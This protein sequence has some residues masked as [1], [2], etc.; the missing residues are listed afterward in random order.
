MPVSTRHDATGRQGALRPQRGGVVLCAREEGRRDDAV[1][2]VAVHLAAALGAKL[3]CVHPP[4][5]RPSPAA[6]ADPARVDALERAARRFAADWIVIGAE[7]VPGKSSALAAQLV[8]DLR[9][10]VVVVRRAPTRDRDAWVLAQVPRD[11]VLSRALAVAALTCADALERPLMAACVL[12]ATPGCSDG[13][14]DLE[15]RI[16]DLLEERE[17][18]TRVAALLPAGKELAGVH[19]QLRRG[20]IATE[21]GTAARELPADVAVVAGD[22]ESLLVD[23]THERLFAAGLAVVVTV[24]VPSGRVGRGTGAR[25]MRAAGAAVAAVALAGL[26]ERLLA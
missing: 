2:G 4:A 6:V 20:R 9:R 14:V 26:V 23:R 21:L 3:R 22:A 1:A 5:P 10:P 8:L 15:G 25:R 16:P 11:E 7:D 18:L 24:P 13:P 19:V 17:A 12:P